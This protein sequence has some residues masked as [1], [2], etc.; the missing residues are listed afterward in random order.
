MWKKIAVA[1][2]CGAAVVGVGTAALATSG[3]SATTAGRLAPSTAPNSAG[4]APVRLGVLPRLGKVAHATWVAKDKDGTY[5]AHNAIHGTVTAVSATSITVK[6]GD[7]VSQ[8]YAVTSSTKV[9]IRANGTGEAGKI[10]DVRTGQNAL[11][12]GTGTTSLTA[13]YVVAGLRK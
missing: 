12:A 9:R 5:V 13:K 10:T 11:V 6:A 2:A 4:N 1:A 8:T 7:G 3:I